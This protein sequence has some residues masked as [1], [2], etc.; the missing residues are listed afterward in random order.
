MDCS[1]AFNS[2]SR[3][4]RP[5]LGVT[6]A[7]VLAL[8]GA[9]VLVIGA[10]LPASAAPGAGIWN[11]NTQPR[12]AADPDTSSVELG[13]VFVSEAD[14]WV[15]AIRY[16]RSA[17]N[18]G[19][20]VGKL[21]S[22]D[23]QMITSVAFKVE[24]PTGWQTA[25]LTSPVRITKGKSYTVSYRAPY[26]RYADDEWVFSN[27]RTIKSGPLTAVRGV[28]TYGSGRPTLAW[29][30]SSY[31]VDVKFTNTN[32]A[33]TATPT[34]TPTSASTASTTTA[35]SPTSTA[36]PSLTTTPS[37]SPKPTP[38]TT[39]VSPS[40]TATGSTT[41]SSATP[42]ASVSPSVTP[43]AQQAG[44]VGSVNSPGGADLWGGCWPG[45]HNTGYPQ[46]LPGDDRAPVTLTSYTGPTTISKCGVVID[47]KI[48]SGEIV[49]TA[50]NGTHSPDTPCVTIKNS[51]VKGVIHTDAASYGPVVVTD[52]EVAVPGL[53][54]WENI[55]RYNVFVWR[56]N[57]HGSEGVIKCADYCAA[58]DSWVHGMYL[59]GSY[60]YNA[61]GG[62]GMESANGYFTIEHN[63]A[64]CGDW[65]WLGS[66]GWVGR[67]LFS[68][69]RF[70]W[71]FC[72]YS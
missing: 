53:S 30:D 51:L 8:I 33:P 39:T 60:H 37:S 14:G 15:T 72:A 23:G 34:A 55:G 40:V 49:V 4:R 7:W 61:F 59:G 29:H 5:V 71:R 9:V 38:A 35:P 32:S 28:Y 6:F 13:T 36:T 2:R 41:T 46:G 22:S 24:S 42:S 12:T 64:S 20:H 31:Y 67:R 25:D 11:D 1:R 16:Y 21:W 52:T 18:R 58:Y 70:L 3:S 27:G 68:R 17:G 69:Y 65:C 54:W 56:V 26:G 47:S 48:V 10:P 44:C 19:P 50:G 43:S 45:A 66:T 57:S 63:W 62:N